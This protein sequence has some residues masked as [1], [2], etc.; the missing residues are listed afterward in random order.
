MV[1]DTLYGT[2]DDLVPQ[3]QMAEGHTIGDDGKRW[4]IKLR[5]GLFFHDGAPVLASDCVASLNRWMK[6]DSFGQTVAQFTDALE[7]PDDRTLVFRLKRP[8]PPL[9]KAL[10][11]TQP[12]PAMIMPARIAATDPFK[13]ITE[14][15]GS[16]PFRF[17]ADEYVPGSRAVFAKFDKYKPRD[18]AASSVAGGKVVHVDRVEWAHHSGGGDRGQRAARR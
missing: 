18:E 4:T 13:Q 10:A 9:I 1:F 6:R 17:V 14:I 12:S 3:P 16:G 7:A 11:K 8:F 2:D 5:D 15:V